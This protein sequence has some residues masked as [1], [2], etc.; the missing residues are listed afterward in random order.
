VN[1]NRPATVLTLSA[2]GLLVPAYLGVFLSRGPTILCPFPAL[3]VVPALMLAQWHLEYAAVL[4][5]ALLFILWNPQLFRA[6]GKIPKRTYVLLALVATLSAVDLALS[7]KWGLRYQGPPHT[8][9]VCSI[10]ITWIGFLGLALRRCLKNAPPFRGSLFVHWMVFA[11]L[12]WYA[13]P[14]LGELI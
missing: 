11:W 3:T 9:I 14:W 5:P 2:A 4:P 8:A 10:N 13:F 12:F 7:W 1:L 6:E